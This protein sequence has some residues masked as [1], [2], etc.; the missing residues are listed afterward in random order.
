MKAYN[1]KTN[2]FQTQ[3]MGKV[4]ERM[5]DPQYARQFVIS[6]NL[7]HKDNS[8]TATLRH[9][10]TDLQPVDHEEFKNIRFQTRIILCT[11]A[12]GWQLADKLA[13]SEEVLVRMALAGTEDIKKYL[14]DKFR[15][16]EFKSVLEWRKD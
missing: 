4:S 16:L 13:K 14:E 3:Y 1:T 10:D 9:I 15:K 8:L 7:F 11:L 2:K 12:E 5:C 6:F